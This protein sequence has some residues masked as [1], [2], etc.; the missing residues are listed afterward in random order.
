MKIIL[1]KF[2]LYIQNLKKNKLKIYIF[3]GKKIYIKKEFTYSVK[4]I[5]KDVALFYFFFLLDIILVLVFLLL[6]LGLLH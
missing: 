2:F 6:C 5:F 4:V 3:A 1:K